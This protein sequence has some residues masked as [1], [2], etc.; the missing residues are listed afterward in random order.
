[1]NRLLPHVA[2]GVP[3]TDLRHMN[4]MKKVDE[5]MGKKSVEGFLTFL[6]HF[7]VPAL[8]AAQAVK[9]SIQKGSTRENLVICFFFPRGGQI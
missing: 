9:V 6:Y 3:P 7:V 1:M 4:G 8:Q 5:S 2:T